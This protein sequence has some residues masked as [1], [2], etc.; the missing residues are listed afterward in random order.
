VRASCSGLLT[1]TG[2]RYLGVAATTWWMLSRFEM[3]AATARKLPTPEMV[4]MRERLVRQLHRELV[5]VY[6]SVRP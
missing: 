2:E 5:W 3:E 4:A 6:A 1:A